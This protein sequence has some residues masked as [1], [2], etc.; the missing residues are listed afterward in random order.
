MSAPERSACA[1][2]VRASVQQPAALVVDRVF[3]RPLA[4][5][6][7]H[8][9]L[10]R[11]RWAP[12][13]SFSAGRALTILLGVARALEHLHSLGICHGDM[14]AHNVLADDAGHAV[15]CDYGTPTRTSR[16]LTKVVV[17]QCLRG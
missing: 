17:C 11:C 5:K 16:C 7:T 8:D 13:T 4:A 14:Y 2:R 10:L 9:S 12:G 15:L 3:G 6:P 1:V